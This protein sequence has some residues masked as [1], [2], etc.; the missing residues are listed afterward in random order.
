MYIRELQ[1]KIIINL[2]TEVI[3]GVKNGKGSFM[4]DATPSTARL[5]SPEEGR[6][7]IAFAYVAVAVA[8]AF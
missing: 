6:E 8:A 3:K 2:K 5:Q 4:Q 7:A 1:K